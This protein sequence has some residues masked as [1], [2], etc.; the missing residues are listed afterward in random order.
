M[1][2][3]ESEMRPMPRFRLNS[4]VLLLALALV[5]TLGN[6]QAA[7]RTHTVKKGDTLWDLAQQYLGDPFKWP[8][9]YRRNTASVQDPNLIYPD[10]VLV[11]D[12]DVAAT[13][14]TPADPSAPTDPAAPMQMDSSAA[15]M[16]PADTTAPMAPSTASNDPGM[17]PAQAPPAMTIFN[18]ERYRVVRGERQSLLVRQPGAAV[19][20]GDYLQAPFLWDP[21]GLVGAGTI[22]GTA[23]ADGIGVTLTERP[24]Q[25]YERIF[26]RIP[27]GSQGVPN[28]R[29]LIVR[30]GPTVA[31]RGR[32]VVPTGVV[33]IASASVNGRADAILLTKFEDV[34]A[35]DQ[36]LIPL[37]TLSLTPGVF[38]THVEFGTQ[39]TVAY[40]YG[41]PVLPPIG[42]QIIFMAGSGDGLQPGDQLTLEREMGND[43][44]GQALPPEAVATATVTRVTAWGA[45]AIIIAQKDGGIVT[46]M[47]ARI[48][49][50]MP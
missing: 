23:Q 25:L 33:K 7:Q 6:A 46:G 37:D 42:H 26:I 21:N 45:S 32:V 2:R 40:I 13:P 11:I 27:A 31:G 48:T 36:M 9:I 49:G 34:Y 15:P 41:N 17:S 12:G 8:D 14:G 30:Y 3:P 18:P 1:N 28:E 35:A 44:R 20:S 5:P 24:I 4:A 39:T 38:P 50:K 16:M 43:E 19:R 47:R 22:D 29:F 10:Q